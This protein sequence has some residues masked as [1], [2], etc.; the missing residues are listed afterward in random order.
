MGFGPAPT[1]GGGG[2]GGS[3]A[4]GLAGIGAPTTA[5]PDGSVYFER[6][7]G[8]ATVAEWLRV[9]G[10]WTQIAGPFPLVSASYSNVSTVTAN[11]PFY[12][13]LDEVHEDASAMISGTDN[14]RIVIPRAGMYAISGFMGYASSSTG[15]RAFAI[16]KTPAAGGPDVYLQYL[17]VNFVTGT[18]ARGLVYRE[19]RMLPG[20]QI[21]FETRS[22]VGLATEKTAAEDPEFAVRMVAP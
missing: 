13:P 7:T 9:A 16:L 2:G 12:Y 4:L 14:T 21:R 17:V 20:D 3:G 1:G 10:A 19:A 22:S 18:N 8:G 11:T 6:N 15:T 5:A